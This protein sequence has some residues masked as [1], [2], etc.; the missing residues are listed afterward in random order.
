MWPTELVLVKWFLPSIRV[1]QMNHCFLCELLWFKRISS[2]NFCRLHKDQI[3]TNV[4]RVISF[5]FPPLALRIRRS[6]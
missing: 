3:E 5:I 1:F 2:I 4:V 6:L